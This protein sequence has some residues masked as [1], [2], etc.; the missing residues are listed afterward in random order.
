M[1]AANVPSLSH[2]KNVHSDTPRT[3]PT[4]KL[5]YRAP[6]EQKK[7][8]SE[9]VQIIARTCTLDRSLLRTPLGLDANVEQ[10]A[11]C[12]TCRACTLG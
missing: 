9:P 10:Q 4:T 1:L 2:A 12:D 7:V 3:S 8:C 5:S 11:V 6:L